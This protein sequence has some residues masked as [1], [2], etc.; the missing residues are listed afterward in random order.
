M[1]TPWKHKKEKFFGKTTVDLF[2]FEN[3]L[4]LYVLRR[5]VAPVFSY[6][7]WYNVG[8][9]NEEKGK[10]GLA[11]LFEHM[12]FKGTKKN[13]QG[14]FDRLMESNGAR[15][16]NAFT[17]TDY[18][19]YVSSLPISVFPMV[20]MLESDRMVGLNLTKSQ[21]E[22][23]REVV[24]NERKQRT[25]NNPDGLIFEELQKLAYQEHPYGR[26]VI[27]WEEDLDQMDIHVCNDF[28]RKFYAP[29]NA[30]IA[31]VGDIDPVKAA[32]VIYKEYGKIKPS[33]IPQLN[34]ACEPMQTQERLKEINV[35]V[36]VEK[37]LMGYRIPVIG[38]KDQLALS[39]L[40]T[41]LSTGRSSRLYRALV[42]E[43][44]TIDIGTGPSPSKD[45]GL[46]YVRFNCQ[47]KVPATE[48]IKILDQEIDSICKNGVTEE[49]L[50]RAKNKTETEIHMGLQSN[51]AL[52]HFIGQTVSVMNSIEPGVKELE[53][54]AHVKLNEVK[55]VALKY[56]NKKN[57]SVLIGRA[58]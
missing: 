53:N 45:D 55:E 14:V 41:I 17:S 33:Q 22:S 24:R 34:V 2:L 51:G 9:L 4:K 11:H 48:A 27:G 43:G 42:D 16:L 20:A 31:I 37:V 26:P 47:M 8:S 1:N 6:Q 30:T 39:V 50:T 38:H 54:I 57:R 56:L 7:T 10:S 15:D 58:S 40:S 29:N 49:E 36:P 28:Y 19:A 12:M 44:K 32:K 5:T 21:F 52:A 35:P 13:P 23:E 3:G 25:D 46:F 18:T